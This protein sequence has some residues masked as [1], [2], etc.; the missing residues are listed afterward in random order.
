MTRFAPYGLILLFIYLL[1]QVHST[2][3]LNEATFSEKLLHVINATEGVLANISSEWQLHN[4]PTLLKSCT[5]HAMAYKSMVSKYQRKILLAETL[6]EQKFI[7]SF[8][9]SSVTAGHDS[10][11]CQA[12]PA[13][14]EDYMKPVFQTLNIDLQARNLAMGNNPCMPYDMC[15]ATYAGFDADIVHWEQTYNCGF[16]ERSIFIEQFIRQTLFYDR[17]PLVVLSGSSTKNWKE[18]DCPPASELLVKNQTKPNR[19]E[20]ELFTSSTSKLVSVLNADQKK[21]WGFIRPIVDK[22]AVAASL[23]L[24]THDHHDRFK[25]QGP[26]RKDW[27]EGIFHL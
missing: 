3:P 21:H 5:M 26:F 19:K 10:L 6:L 11:I 4:F 27:G 1:L 23:Q 24:F 25:C 7:I 22:Y 18:K 13:L 2:L 8:L 9:G 16:G 17:R 14:V 20:M 15:V 12:F